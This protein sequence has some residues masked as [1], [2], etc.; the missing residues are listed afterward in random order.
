AGVGTF[1]TGVVAYTDLT[2][3]RLT[4]RH[5]PFVLTA[6]MA[7]R[8][9]GDRD[10]EAD[11]H[12]NIPAEGVYLDLTLPLE[13]KEETPAHDVRLRDWAYLLAPIVDYAD[14]R[15]ILNTNDGETIW[16]LNEPYLWN[17]DYPP[18]AQVGTATDTIT[19]ADWRAL[20]EAERPRCVFTSPY[21]IHIDP[22]AD[23]RALTE[24][25][26]SFITIPA[27]YEDV[28]TVTED[29]ELLL[30]CLP[31]DWELPDFH[32]Y[33]YRE[34]AV[35]FGVHSY[36]LFGREVRFH[37]TPREGVVV[38]PY[39][40]GSVYV[41]AG[42]DTVP[43]REH[44]KTATPYHAT[45]P[46]LPTLSWQDVWSRTQTMTLRATFYDVWDWDSCATCERPMEQHAGFAVTFGIYAD[47]DGDSEHETLVREI[48]TRLDDAQLQLLGK[49][50][51]QG[52]S[53]LTI[54]EDENL[55]QLPIFHG[56]GIKIG[57]EGAT[58]D[59]SW[60]SVGP[61]ASELFTVTE[62]MAYDDLFFRQVIPPGS[63]ASFIVS[64]TIENYPFNREGQFKIHDGGR[65]VYRQQIAG[66]NRYE[67]YDAHVHVPEGV[68][69]DGQIAKQ[70][71]PTAVSIYNDT[72][73]FFYDVWDEAD[74]RPYYDPGDPHRY[75]PY[76]KSW[77]YG[78][79]VWTTYAG[80]SEKKTLFHTVLGPGD[81]TRVRVSFDNNTG[82]TVTHLSVALDAPA[83]VTVTHLYTDPT[84]AS[85]PE[86]IWP[87]LAFLN[88]STVPDAWRSVW[89][90]DLVVGEE[91]PAELWGQVAE[92]PVAITADN[93][94]ADYDAPPAR[95]G[96]KRAADP[97]PM[98]TSGPAHSLVLTDALPSEVTVDAIA[99]LTDTATRDALEAALD[100]DAGDPAAD[101]ASDLFAGLSTTVPFT[102]EGGVLTVDLP[103]AMRQLPPEGGRLS[104]V[105]KADLAR[106]H[107]GPNIVNEGAGI[108]YTDPFGMRWTA[109]SESAIVE[110]HGAAL[111]VEYECGGGWGESSLE[112][113]GNVIASE[114]GGC[115]IPSYGPAEVIIYVTAYNAGDAIARESQIA[116]DIPWSV[117]PSW[118]DPMWDAFIE[119]EGRQ[120]IWELG[121]MAPGQWKEFT[122]VLWLDPAGGE[123]E[124]ESHP[125]ETTASAAPTEGRLVGIHHTDGDFFDDY[126]QQQISAQIGGPLLLN[127]H[128]A[129]QFVYL[130]TVLR[131]YRAPISI[132]YLVGTPILQRE[133]VYQGEVFYRT[134]FALPSE[135]PTDGRYYLSS[136][137]DSVAEI[138]VDDALA[139]VDANGEDAFYYLFSADGDPPA[140][141]EPAI[142]E[143]PAAT[144]AQLAGQTVTLEYRDV[145]AS[146]VEATEVWLIYV[147]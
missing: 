80:G 47:L 100:H 128:R 3:E 52:G 19:L 82:I 92:I 32:G 23:R 26:G 81:R 38:L 134:T 70:A 50:Y 54:P 103:D 20:P 98:Y 97:M 88:R 117:E 106:A 30:P 129:P 72:L 116:L 113:T 84:A 46:D 43:F 40:A 74:A 14:Q 73:L 79:A 137:S 133:I 114:G 143:I 120:L 51:S 56:L 75:D 36:E 39:D 132:P 142:V 42:T 25:F 99:W 22:P 130:P 7:A 53:N 102:V 86:P 108:A 61:G 4:A 111:W 96:F 119:G 145:F 90:F 13:N 139:L 35:R 6:R 8:L 28:I 109:R 125:F 65:L 33:M 34:P 66:P 147:P 44:L 31:L 107:H 2:G 77:G 63:W 127:V 144:M 21:G 62:G 18:F 95:L 1:S 93:L 59:D 131:N 112:G 78:D 60:R 123:W 85:T 10:L 27:G 15:V 57:P 121:D 69:S 12:F 115:S 45:P 110:A 49:T 16:M 9:V 5:P 136:S 37:G 48:P 101:T 141:P 71:G 126:S 29:N 87:E 17:G 140:P 41:M 105:A 138:M 83:G 146:V 124:G 24:D 135:L 11:R 68:S 94:P 58:W 55:I 91:L 67:V 104:L 122:I 64:A 76:I 118:A 89:Y